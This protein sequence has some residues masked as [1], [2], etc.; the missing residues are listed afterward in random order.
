MSSEENATESSVSPG[1][2]RALRAVPGVIAK[3]SSEIALSPPHE[4]PHGAVLA[5]RLAHRAQPLTPTTLHP[6]RPVTLAMLGKRSTEPSLRVPG[7]DSGLRSVSQ[8]HRGGSNESRSYTT[9]TFVASPLA[10]HRSSEDIYQS[11]VAPR[12]S[13]EQEQSLKSTSLLFSRSSGSGSERLS[14]TQARPSRRSSIF[15]G[16]L[17]PV[18]REPRLSLAD[19]VDITR[20][21]TE[22]LSDQTQLELER[23]AHARSRPRRSTLTPLENVVLYSAEMSSNLDLEAQALDSEGRLSGY[24]PLPDLPARSLPTS[25]FSQRRGHAPA[26][27]SKHP[28]ARPDS[29]VED[30]SDNGAQPA[31]GKQRAVLGPIKRA[32]SNPK[33][34]DSPQATRDQELPSRASQPELIVSRSLAALRIPALQVSHSSSETVDTED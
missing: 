28:L 16:G 10:K 7:D 26:N 12:L 33:T 8:F 1:R 29:S 27:Q 22:Q 21:Q 5:D 2:A 32:N 25:P 17:P 34:E 30:S 19:L 15:D 3:K 18:S 13:E 31:F 14:Q 23:A 24:Q 9:S 6:T 20:S 4:L 11:D